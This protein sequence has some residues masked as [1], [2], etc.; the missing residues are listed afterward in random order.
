MK[1]SFSSSNF[2]KLIAGWFA[3]MRQNRGDWTIAIILAAIASLAVQLGT[4]S[5]E[6]DLLADKTFDDVWFTADIPRV[7]R[8]MAVS[9]QKGSLR[10]FL[11]PLFSEFT[12]PPILILEHVFGL[13]AI[14]SVKILMELVAALWMGVFYA[15]LRVIGCRRLD[16]T[17][18]TLLAA[19]SAS[20]MF[21]FV[22]PETFSF[23]SLGILLALAI[24]PL[25]QRFPLSPPWYIAAN[26]LTLSFTVTNWMFGILATAVNHS[27]KRS[28][29]ILLASFC[30]V[31]VLSVSIPFLGWLSK[32]P[33][34][35]LVL[36]LLLGS[37]LLGVVTVGTI[38][39]KRAHPTFN[40]LEFAD[41]LLQQRPVQILAGGCCLAVAA[42][43]I[44]GELEFMLLPQ[45]GGPL[46]A[47]RAF[48]LHSM[49]M[50]AIRLVEM[51][52]KNDISVMPKMTIQVAA[53]GS[54][55]A[56]G[57][58]AVGLWAA[59]LGLGFWSL[60]V[61]KVQ[62]KLRLVL[63]LALVG[64]L[65]IHLVYGAETFLYVLDFAPVLLAIAA[66][67]T[68][69]RFRLLALTLAGLVTL[70]AGANNIVQYQQ[71]ID[72]FHNYGTSQPKIQK[73]SRSTA[74][75]KIDALS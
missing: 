43:Q 59:L 74:F 12:F 46:A 54:G 64:Q 41:T 19:T 55:S 47:I 63:G 57:G 42:I 9:P 7:V 50:P 61:L 34:H 32:L 66:L 31:A 67:S 51:V 5:I 33:F 8:S 70:S 35:S 18:F 48:L 21:W 39:F 1:L 28:I 13:S 10:F 56:W 25:G 45:S 72:Y 65:L 58:V 6:I 15:L 40:P 52:E 73:H 69:T 3:Q 71:A 30:L 17:I 75:L 23:S 36:V 20:A 22:V 29:Q 38:F 26:V 68:L 24:I 14:A 44:K 2:G 60:F 49:V 37:V 27:R 11:H 16:A 62:G 53:A 4:Q